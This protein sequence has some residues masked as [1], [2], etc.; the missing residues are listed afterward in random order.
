MNLDDSIEVPVIFLLA[1]VFFLIAAYFRRVSLSGWKDWTGIFQQVKP[2]LESSPS[3]ADKVF[4]GVNGCIM[5]IANW[6][7][8]AIFIATGIDLIFAGGQHVIDA[9]NHL[10]AMADWLFRLLVRIARILAAIAHLI[11]ESSG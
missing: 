7:L 2:N 5:G 3:A 1:L 10:P 4:L 6:V 8:M 9:Y 11:A